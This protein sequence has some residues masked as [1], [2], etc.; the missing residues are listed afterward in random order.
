MFNACAHCGEYVVEKTVD[1]ARS[2]ANCPICG[3]E[4]PFLR[5]PVFVISGASGAGKTA[6]CRALMPELRLR[7]VVLES[8]ILWDAVDASAE[9]DYRRYRNVWLRLA[10]NIG[11]A[12]LPVV[13]CGTALSDQFERCSERRY[14]SM[15]HYLALVC[16]EEMLRER[17]RQRPAW[18]Q[19]E[20]A[21]FLE[22]MTTFNRW[23]V[24][25]A[26]TTTPPMTLL[27]TT[28]DALD[29]TVAK[30][31]RWIVERL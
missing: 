22:R 4:Q 5:Q 2:I 13:L 29:E 7:C 19:S 31:A 12:G 14:F 21:E 27:D 20:S 6:V 10:K 24:E 1:A 17:L 30:V 18:R 25:H 16:D 9:D 8:D 11:Q 15:L 26:P 23:L 3:Y 28:A